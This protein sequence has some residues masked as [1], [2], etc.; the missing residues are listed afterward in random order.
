LVM[1]YAINRDCSPLVNV[2]AVTRPFRI[3]VSVESSVVDPDPLNHLNP[4]PQHCFLQQQ[5]LEMVLYYDKIQ[6][7]LK[8]FKMKFKKLENFMF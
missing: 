7:G 4:D 8:K 5:N 2:V 1:C 3:F 6:D